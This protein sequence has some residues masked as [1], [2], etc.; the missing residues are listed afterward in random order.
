[1]KKSISYTLAAIMLSGFLC[2]GAETDPAY[3]PWANLAG[4][5]AMLG[6]ALILRLLN[7]RKNGLQNNTRG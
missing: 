1:M 2:A 3:W 7:R 4:G 5:V 6:A